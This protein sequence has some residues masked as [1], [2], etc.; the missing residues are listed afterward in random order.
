LPAPRPEPPALQGRAASARQEPHSAYAAS[1]IQRATAT[2]K[3]RKRSKSRPPTIKS[4]QGDHVFPWVA[5][6]HTMENRLRGLSIETQA[7]D[8]IDYAESL[9]E[10]P[11]YAY[12]PSWYKGQLTNWIKAAKATDDP[13]QGTIDIWVKQLLGY[14]NALPLSVTTYRKSSGGHN[15]KVLA[16]LAYYDKLAEDG[17]LTDPKKCHYD[18]V[19]T[20]WSVCDYHPPTSVSDDEIAATLAQ[21]IDS[22]EWAYPSLFAED[23]L[24]GEGEILKAL[25]GVMDNFLDRVADASTRKAGILTKIQALL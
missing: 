12:A 23:G 24:V 19:T 21:F 10:L 17:K 5:M 13:D 6:K 20:V 2:S 9:T 22:M 16:H 8:L 18:P 7:E 4:K 3:K 15:E 25:P 1:A 11:G 14:R